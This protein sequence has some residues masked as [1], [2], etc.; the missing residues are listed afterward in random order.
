MQPKLLSESHNNSPR[1]SSTIG[2]GQNK[3]NFKVMDREND[4]NSYNDIV[5]QNSFKT[6]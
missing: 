5:P 2:S 1:V 6:E 3:R 4:F